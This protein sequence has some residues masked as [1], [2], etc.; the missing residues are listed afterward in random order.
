MSPKHWGPPL[1]DAINIITRCYPETPSISDMRNYRTFFT[2]LGN[3][4]PCRKCQRHYRA[5]LSA[6]GT[7]PAGTR[8][9]LVDFVANLHNRV[10]YATGKPI[11]P[12]PEARAHIMAAGK[13][14]LMP[15]IVKYIAIAVITL[16]IIQFLTR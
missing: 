6:I 11:M 5:H 2:A 16:F 14:G 1:W 15:P 4:L 13:G 9:E 10:N 8:N 3:V 7:I 12:L